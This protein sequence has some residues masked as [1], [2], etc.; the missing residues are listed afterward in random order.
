ML[1]YFKSNLNEEQNA[2]VTELLKGITESI[3]RMN[4][5]SKDENIEYTLCLIT[6]DAR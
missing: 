3:L 5:E 6:E 4:H 1:S 2:R